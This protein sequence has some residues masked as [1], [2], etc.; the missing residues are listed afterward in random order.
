VAFVVVWFGLAMVGQAFQEVP[1][2]HSVAVA[3]GLVPMLAQWVTQIVDLA[4]R[5]AGA[6]LLAVAPRFGNELAIYGMIALG[7]GALLVSMIWAAALVWIVDRQFVKASAWMF[8]GAVLSCF[9]VIH[10][11]RITPQGIENHL[12]WWVAPEFTLSY[13]A[14]ATFLLICHAYATNNPG[15]FLNSDVQD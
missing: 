2:A 10:A 4:I 15:A 1:A 14:A 11:Y 8:A 6:N 13:A 12:G 9:G 7:Q 5:K 3:L